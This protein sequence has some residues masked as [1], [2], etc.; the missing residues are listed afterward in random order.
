MFEIAR[1]PWT[2]GWLT[3]IAAIGLG[4]PFVGASAVLLDVATTAIA[5]SGDEEWQRIYPDDS[6]PVSE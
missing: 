4:L 2:H 3:S 5:R 6:T 1:E